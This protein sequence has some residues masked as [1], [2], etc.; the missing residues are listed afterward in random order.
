MRSKS[1]P[2]SALAVAM[3][4]AALALSG[5][6]TAAS[7]IGANFV[8]DNNGGVQDGAT[9]SLLAEESAG[10]PSY[11]QANWNNLGRW[12]QTTALK[13]SSGAA[14]GVTATWDAN[15]TW[16]TGAGTG[17][18]HAKLMHGYLDATGAGTGNNETSTDPGAYH[19]FWNENKP[20]AYVTGISAWLATQGATKYDVVVYLDGDSTG[21]RI[22]ECWLQAGNGGDPPNT[23]GAD[24]TAHAFARDDANFAGTYTQVPASANSV[25][26]AAA[27]NYVVFNDV[28]ADSFILRTEERSFHAAFITGFQIVPRIAAI[29]P[30]I[31]TQPLSTT[32]YSGGTVTFSAAA[33]GTPPFTY[34]WRRNGT[35]LTDG[36]AISGA[37]TD[38][39]TITGATAVN[40]SDY[41]LAVTNSGDTTISDVAALGIA[42]APT[43]GSYAATLVTGDAVA[44]W[45]LNEGDSP[46]SGNLSANDFIGGHTGKYGT[47]S[48]TGGTGPEAPAL[49]GFESGNPAVDIVPNGA[50]PA[51]VT[52]PTPS[53]NSNTV[54]IAGWVHPLGNQVD[55]SA[56]FMTRGAGTTAGLIFN[57]GDNQLGYSWNGDSAAT[58]GWDSNLRPPT[59]E[60]SFVVL[61]IEPTKATLYLGSN[62]VLSSA[63]NTIA[64][65]PEAWGINARIGNDPADPGKTFNGMI[66]EVALFDR[67]LSYDDVADLYETATGIPQTAPAVVTSNPASQSRYT[68]KTVQL[69]AAATGT[70]PV[71]YQ[72]LRNDEPLTNG[73]NISGATT[74]TLVITNATTGNT[75]D[76]KLVATNSFGTD[77]SEIAT[78]AIVTPATAHENQVLAA[79]PLAFWRLDEST[80]PAGGGVA[81]HDYA[82]GHDGV[83]GTAVQNGFHAISGPTQADG[84]S[85]FG[86]SNNAIA[87]THD[88]ANSYVTTPTLGLTT[89]TFT[90]TGWVR[91]DATPENWSGLV[92][93]RGGTPATGLNIN[94]SGQLG[95]HWGDSFWDVESGLTLP[96]NEW[97]F[98]AL[99]VQPTQA[100]LY[101]YN[102]DGMESFTHIAGHAALA[103]NSGFRLGGDPAGDDRIFNGRID[104]VAVFGSALTQEQIVTLVGATFPT[105]TLDRLPSGNIQ[106]NWS[107]GALY[108]AE[109]LSGPWT[110]VPG[111]TSPYSF[112][113]VLSRQ[114]FRVQT[115]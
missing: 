95:Y 23:L 18:P 33:T 65:T 83:Y 60:W 7:S 4:A 68:G 61:V 100:T 54:T 52:V 105:I 87:C 111:A 91:P 21:G 6:A 93:T 113:P 79:N 32:V 62:G 25:A 45:R 73:G 15:N 74:D 72:W 99:V 13:D 67:A 114:F 78:L 22:C 76:Y 77:T 71:T 64:H 53:L 104:E 11:E 34:Q 31:A 82:G 101:V 102:S 108:Q 66:D 20:E 58:W 24:L 2:H 49:P 42:A 5:H 80:D 81:A 3:T 28:T 47:H 88:L 86:S 48:M 16:N 92:F 63:T 55:G 26:N 59:S 69:M 41:T 110:P 115:P 109:D 112:A 8:T 107:G 1:K 40:A 37:T 27:G 70:S 57:S 84:Y 30:T 9:D 38:T 56:I 94:G 46:G 36:G 10:A 44:H 29:P 96:A 98:V 19:F 17:N 35:P 50:N 103:L 97:S 75:G 43:A 89:N 85:M 106:L 51:W 90:I 14:S 39:L 12:G